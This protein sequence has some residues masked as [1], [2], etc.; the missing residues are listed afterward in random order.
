MTNYSDEFCSHQVIDTNMT[1]NNIKQVA[2][3][4]GKYIGAM[5]GIFDLKEPAKKIVGNL[6]TGDV[7]IYLFRRFGYPLQGW[8]KHKELVVYYLNTSMP[9]VVLSVQP[10]IT[11][12]G[13]FGYL[14][15]EDIDQKCV[16][17]QRRPY[18]KWRAACEEWILQTY[19]IEII[20]IFEQDD[21]KVKRIWD[22]WTIDNREKEFRDENDIYDQF[23]KDQEDIRQK[24]ADLYK[25]LNTFP[26]P[27]PYKDMDDA[28]ILK[29]CFIALCDAIKDLKTPITIRD[30]VINIT[31]TLSD[32]DY[33]DI[34]DYEG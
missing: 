3:L 5:G 4:E 10:N 12:T 7:F 6:N 19:G 20:W 16:L 34:I 27:V 31:G 15:K 2:E 18:E 29:Q 13:T 11:R 9:G 30:V 1:K 25:C 22:K 26:E 32:V 23:F 21:E 14:L 28:S 24:Y 33:D 8:D 17:E